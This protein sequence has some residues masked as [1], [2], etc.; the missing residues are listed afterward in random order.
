M[1]EDVEIITKEPAFSG[2]NYR[3][4]TSLSNMDEM[5]I[6]EAELDILSLGNNLFKIY[7]KSRSSSKK[8]KRDV[9]TCGYNSSV[10]AA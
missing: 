10:F 3:E 7:N 4:F 1:I 6:R 2:S 9:D 5:I 8:R